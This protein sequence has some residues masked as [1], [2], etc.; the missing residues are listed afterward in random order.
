MSNY[1]FS[2]DI[3]YNDKEI[4][5]KLQ[6][7]LAQYDITRFKKKK[8]QDYLEKVKKD[9][10]KNNKDTLEWIEIEEDGTKYIVKLVERKKEVKE[11]EYTYQSIIASKNA[12]ITSIKAYSGEKVKTVNQYVQKGET[13]ISGVMQ[14]PDGTNIF[15]KA[16]GHVYGEVWYK[17]NLEYPLYYQ[18][19]KVTGKNKTIITINFLDK[20]IPLFPYKKYKQLKHNSSKILE[21]KLLPISLTKENLYEVIVK[22]EIYTEEKAV[23]IAK[24]LAEKKLKEKNNKIIK[25][26]DIQIL[27]KVNLGSKI[28]LNLFISVNED[29]TEIIE[30]KEE[31]LEKTNK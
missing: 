7:E 22:E 15:E 24:K 18:E 28:K 20:Q 2:I 10:L 4:V 8:T 31:M 6:K 1:I 3:I 14:K 23:S 21:S 11:N 29:I 27:E 5:N 17:V 12:T 26:N 9:I 25:I 30:V 19:E 16:K 13:I